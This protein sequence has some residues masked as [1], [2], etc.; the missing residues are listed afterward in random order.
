MSSQAYLRVHNCKFLSN[1]ILHFGFSTAA[2]ALHFIDVASSPIKRTTW[3]L[4]NTAWEHRYLFDLATRRAASCTLVNLVA[5]YVSFS[6]VASLLVLWLEPKLWL[7]YSGKPY[8][9]LPYKTCSSCNCGQPSFSS[10][11]HQFA[12]MATHL[13]GE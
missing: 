9:D 6:I 4:H 11:G 12:K 13:L 7:V 2:R 10:I 8:T 1:T 3:C 5:S